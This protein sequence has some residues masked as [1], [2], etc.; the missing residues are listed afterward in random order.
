MTLYNETVYDLH[1]KLTKKE[2]SSVE[3]T[4]KVFDRIDKVEDSV[5]A[6]ITLD[7]EGALKKAREVDQKIAAGE[8]IKPLTGIPG[9]IKDLSLIHI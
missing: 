8:A 2:I 1:E 3:L 6:Y 7:K 4:E 9:A 5:K